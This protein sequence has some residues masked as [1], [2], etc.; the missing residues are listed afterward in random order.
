MTEEEQSIGKFTRKKLLNL[1]NWDEWEAAELKQLEQFHKQKMLG[2]PINPKLL[3][4]DSIILRPHW[5]H[6]AK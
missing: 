4:K 5:Q 6:V 1:Q 3:G 2:D